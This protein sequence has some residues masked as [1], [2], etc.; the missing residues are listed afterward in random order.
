MT[1]SIPVMIPGTEPNTSQTLEIKVQPASADDGTY[2]PV[3]ALD[4]DSDISIGAVSQEGTWVV[5]ANAGTNL[6]T[7]SLA[8]EGGGNL[9]TIAGTVSGGKLKVDPSGVTSP[10]SVTSLPALA[11][12]TNDIGGVYAAPTSSSSFAITPGS[13]AALESSHILKASAGNLYSLYAFST[14]SGFLMTFNSSTAPSNGA[15]NPVE[16]IPVFANSFA[17]IDFSGVP[18]DNYS[19]GIVAA[20]STTGPF[21]FTASATAFFKWR[22][23]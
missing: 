1:T 7:S 23:Q 9:A 14:V 18:P 17:T 4:A 19:D 6:N 3:V 20:F 8:L 2:V 15:V 21:T 13:S 16:C 10:V 22:I 11:A 12:G 5:T